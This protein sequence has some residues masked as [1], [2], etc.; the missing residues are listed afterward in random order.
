MFSKMYLQW[1]CNI[2]CAMPMNGL[3]HD[4]FFMTQS[5]V[6]TFLAEWGDRSQIA[7]IAVWLISLLNQLP[8]L[9]V[10]RHIHFNL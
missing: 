9:S 8:N 4:F 5:F 3:M 6:L 1:R 10:S 7:T 2:A